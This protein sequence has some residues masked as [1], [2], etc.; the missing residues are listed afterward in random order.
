MTRT[1]KD[2]SH[3]KKFLVILI[4]SILWCNVSFA[5][6]KKVAV[7]ANDSGTVYIDTQTVSKI[8]NNFIFMQLNSYTIPLEASGTTWYSDIAKVEVDC[9]NNNSRELSVT[10]YE[11][12][13]GKGNIIASSNEVDDW[14]HNIQGSIMMTVVD[15]FCK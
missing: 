4:L 2:D 5:E 15:Y 7:A 3:A 8:G 13:M 9:T 1:I 12:K 6:W 10:F 14:D 11:K